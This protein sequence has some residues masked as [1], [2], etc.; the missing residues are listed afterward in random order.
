MIG[1]DNDFSTLENVAG[2][3]EEFT[4]RYISDNDSASQL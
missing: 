3:L 1:L 2:W 4:D